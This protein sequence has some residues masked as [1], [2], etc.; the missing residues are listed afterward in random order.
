MNASSLPVLLGAVVAHI[1]SPTFP[2]PPTQSVR[3]EFLKL[4]N[5]TR[6]SLVTALRTWLQSFRMPGEAQIIDRLLECFANAYCRDN[7]TQFRHPDTAYVLAVSVIM[8]NTDLYNPNV[9]KK[10]PLDTFIR[11]NQGINAGQD[12]DRDILVDL[13]ND[14]AVRSGLY[15]CLSVSLSL[16]LSVS[17]S[18]QFCLCNSVSAILSLQFCLSVSLSV[19]VSVCHCVYVYVVVHAPSDRCC[20]RCR[21]KRSNLG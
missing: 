9:R 19:S 6:L 11:V 1:S 2:L 21:P 13:Y 17:L 7:P 14:I 4:F 20:R 5:F 16:C 12:V 10:M 15:L 8:L 18:L 3:R